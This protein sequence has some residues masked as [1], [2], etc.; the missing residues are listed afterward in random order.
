MTVLSRNVLTAQSRSNNLKE[1]F[2]AFKSVNGIGPGEI[3][4]SSRQMSGIMSEMLSLKEIPAKAIT[5]YAFTMRRIPE[6]KAAFTHTKMLVVIARALGY[7]HYDEMIRAAVGE[8][9]MVINRNHSSC[10][11]N[12]RVDVEKAAREKATKLLDVCLEA[13]IYVKG[14]EIVHSRPIDNTISSIAEWYAE[15]VEP[16]VKS[17]GILEKDCK[18]PYLIHTAFSMALAT[19]YK[20]VISREICKKAFRE[21]EGI[22]TAAECRRFAGKLYS[23]KLEDL[24]N[25][26][27]DDVLTAV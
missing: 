16:A 13:F 26:S 24:T 20:S 14:N 12:V 11:E 4:D 22:A 15:I 1:H 19:K 8:D 9:R 2:E 3:P 10:F 18:V 25:T 17:S 27:A 23:I 7:N 5:H 6:V 21:I